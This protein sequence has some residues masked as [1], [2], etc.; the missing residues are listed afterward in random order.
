MTVRLSDAVAGLQQDG[1]N[2]PFGWQ[3][4][5]SVAAAADM[6]TRLRVEPGSEEGL[7]VL[8]AEGRH[9]FGCLGLDQ[10]R[11]PRLA[12]DLEPSRAPVASTRTVIDGIL[13]MGEVYASLAVNPTDF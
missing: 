11:R 6:R 1:A 4:W 2:D 12:F 5:P 9:R 7:G 3:G 8:V 10:L 13:S